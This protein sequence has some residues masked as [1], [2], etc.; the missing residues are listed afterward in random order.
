MT[1]VLLFLI[2]N[3]VP[4]ELFNVWSSLEVSLVVVYMFLGFTL[5]LVILLKFFVQ[6]P[7][8]VCYVVYCYSFFGVLC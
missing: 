2:V 4:F 7:V 1:F 3:F 8:M 5:F 6:I